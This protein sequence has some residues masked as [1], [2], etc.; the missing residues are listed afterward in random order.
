MRDNLSA[1]TVTFPFTDIEPTGRIRP[2]HSAGS[3][4]S[5]KSCEPEGHRLERPPPRRS[6]VATV[7]YEHGLPWG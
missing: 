7:D 4:R 2:R 3:A 5:A 6:S 1:D